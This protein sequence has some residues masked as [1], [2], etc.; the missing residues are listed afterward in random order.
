MGVVAGFGGET[1]HRLRGLIGRRDASG[2]CG[3][4]GHRTRLEHA[5]RQPEAVFAQT[6]GGT[7]VVV[8]DH[9]TVMQHASTASLM[10]GY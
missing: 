6:T 10:P 2:R 7:P 4:I 8:P 1:A 3:E 5:V 9:H